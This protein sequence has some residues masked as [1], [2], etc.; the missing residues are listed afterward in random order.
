MG[1]EQQI[2]SILGQTKTFNLRKTHNGLMIIIGNMYKSP[3]LSFAKLLEL[4]QLFG[5][6]EIDVDNYS[7]TGCES[8]DWGSDYG[9]EISIGNP[10]EYLEE[11]KDL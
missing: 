3:E 10:T 5:T 1:L 11:I 7:E 2:I 6:T 8:C 4:S 9:H